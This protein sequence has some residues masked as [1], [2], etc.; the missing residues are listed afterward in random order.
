MRSWLR[1]AAGKLSSALLDILCPQEV[2]CLCCGHALSPEDEGELC[3]VCIQALEAL[4]AAQ[5]ERGW[6][7]PPEGVDG[8]WCA[9]PYTGEAR[10]LILQLKYAHVRKAAKPLGRAMAQLPL[11]EAD[12]LVPVPTTK[13]RERERGYNQAQVL[14]EQMALE[15]GMP[16]RCSL[17]RTQERRK[18][19]GLSGFWR[20]RNLAGTMLADDAV[21]GMRVLLVDDVLTTGAT[22]QEAAR[23]LRQA[24]AVGVYA[25]AAG[26]SMD[27]RGNV[28]RVSRAKDGISRVTGG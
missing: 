23:A 2:V 20:R 22:M 17:R 24:G 25:A 12:M 4:E 13:R 27:T 7:E 9:Y 19:T 26:K 10:R 18:Q 5:Q 8:V 1:A 6:I 15:T 11:G 21:R 14:C 16:M 3:Q 28:L